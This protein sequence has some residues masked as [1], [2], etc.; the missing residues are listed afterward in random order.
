MRRQGAALESREEE[1]GTALA[2][3]GLACSGGIQLLG[4]FLCDMRNSERVSASTSQAQP[5]G[6]FTQSQGYYARP[7]LT[8]CAPPAEGRSA[9]C[10]RLPLDGPSPPSL[11]GRRADARALRPAANW[12]SSEQHY[13]SSSSFPQVEPGP[14]DP[15]VLGAPGRLWLHPSPVAGRGLPASHKAPAPPALPGARERCAAAGAAA[16]GGNRGALLSS[17]AKGASRAATRARGAGRPSGHGRPAPPSRAALATRM[18]AVGH[19]ACAHCEHGGRP[20]R[21]QCGPRPGP[22]WHGS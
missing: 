7:K 6:I 11:T 10:H 22:R 2:P 5:N 16:A 9:G 8:G 3:P 18:A 1:A 13:Q 20:G 4:F 12:E 21:L 19:A 15:A 17:A 14:A